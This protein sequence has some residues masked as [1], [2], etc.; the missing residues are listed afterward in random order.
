[1]DFYIAD[2]GLQQKTEKMRKTVKTY[3]MTL[4]KFM[5]FISETYLNFTDCGTQQFYLYLHFLSGPLWDEIFLQNQC[6]ANFFSIKVLW[7]FN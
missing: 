3:K 2:S 4:K 6:W 5:D 7:K 1:M